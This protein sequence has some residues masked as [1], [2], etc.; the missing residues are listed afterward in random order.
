VEPNVVNLTNGERLMMARRRANKT[1]E[2]MRDSLGLSKLA[3]L[4]LEHD[5]EHVDWTK[6]LKETAA[7]GP[8]IRSIDT[9]QLHERCHLSR[10][11]QG[12]T[13][14][15][16]AKEVGCSKQWVQK[17]ETAQQRCDTLLD[18]WARF[19]AGKSN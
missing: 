13:Q 17:M 10:L 3:Y 15:A 18:F 5:E 16:L 14:S 4:R 11:R 2:E 6:S 12:M 1:Q 19:W 9:I 8:F 7:L